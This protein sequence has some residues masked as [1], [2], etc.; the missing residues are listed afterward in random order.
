MKEIYQNPDYLKI[1]N[2]E[3][4]RAIATLD[5][6][7]L[8]SRTFQM[9]YVN[10]NQPCVVKGAALHWK[11]CSSWQSLDYL[12]SRC[13]DVN[14]EVHSTPVIEADPLL[15]TPEKKAWLAMLRLTRNP[16]KMR[17]AEFLDQAVSEDGDISDLFFLYSIPLGPGGPLEALRQ[18]VAAYPFLK[19][20]RKAIFGTYPQNN[21]YFYRSSLTDWHYHAS[22]EALQT[23]VLGTKEVLLLPPSELV[24]SYMFSLQSERLH[25]YDAELSPFPQ[26]RQVI[27]FRAVLH[28]GDA[29]Y[30]PTFWWHLVSTRGNRFLG[31]TVPTWWRSPFHIQCDPRFPAARA[32]MRSLLQGALPWWQASLLFPVLMTGVLWSTARRLF[33]PAGERES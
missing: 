12:K 9:E 20:M 7:T 18:D 1:P 11:A 10:R 26:S 3:H 13:G 30:I 32:L 29:L 5:A 2:Y 4:A 33:Q 17:F 31:A 19:D 27:P 6:R 23:Q 14:V 21:V 16:V 22:A 24:W 28:P 8:T 25:L 15:S